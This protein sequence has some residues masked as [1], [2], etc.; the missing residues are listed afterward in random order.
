MVAGDREG[1]SRKTQKVRRSP[2]RGRPGVDDVGVESVGGGRCHQMPL[3][4]WRRWKISSPKSSTDC[5]SPAS[6]GAA[7]RTKISRGYIHTY[8]Y[9]YIHTY[10]IVHRVVWSWPMEARMAVED[11]PREIRDDRRNTWW[12]SAIGDRS[13]RA[14]ETRRRNRKTKKKKKKKKKKRGKPRKGKER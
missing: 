8:I 14:R 4:R 6:V 10:I 13:A 9:I 5:S 3:W 7:A 2:V 1:R 12:S 11:W